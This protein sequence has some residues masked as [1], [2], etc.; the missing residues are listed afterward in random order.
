[1]LLERIKKLWLLPPHLSRKSS[2]ALVIKSRSGPCR[3]PL[4]GTAERW[5]NP[6]LAILS[7]GIVAAI[8]YGSLFPF[9]FLYGILDDDGAV[10]A[11]IATWR[12][13]ASRGDLIANVLFYLPLGFFLVQA[14]R[15]PPPIVRVLLALLL[16]AGLSVCME[17]AQFYLPDRYTSMSDVYANTAG[18]LL[19]AIVGLV[20]RAEASL[21]ALRARA[22]HPFPLLLVTSWLGYRLFPFVPVID[23]HK[24]WNALKPV[25]TAPAF[26][27]LDLYCHAVI[28]LAIGLLFES[29]FG[30]ARGRLLLLL[31]VPALLF[32]RVLIV[33]KILSPSEVAGAVI[34][35]AI[36]CAG[37]WR[38]RARAP[39]VAILFATVV[40][41]RAL[42]PFQFSAMA[43]P[44]G[45]I[46]FFSLLQASPVAGVLSFFEKVFMYGALIWLTVRAGCSLAIAAA[47]DGVL[48][49]CLKIAQL[50]LPRSAEITDII[51]LLALAAVM[52]LMKEQAPHC[53]EPV[54]RPLGRGRVAMTQVSSPSLLGFG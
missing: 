21:P 43:R 31:F 35:A 51:I 10:R 41:L 20:V 11:L 54:D 6:K 18:T 19:G 30:M 48:V 9:N 50:Y 26:S 44:F 34:A 13:G 32:A 36:W 1:M 3:A 49:L 7:G 8:V 16:G 25:V 40:V 12:S 29:L 22:W 42:E 24:Y 37:L 28:W 15:R 2:A 53:S 5:T 27:G 46:P 23:L 14:L 4:N 39:I 17:L 45:W 52:S 38:V 33:G 47:F